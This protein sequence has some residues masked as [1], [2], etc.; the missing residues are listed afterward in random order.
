MN[1]RKKIIIIF[2]IFILLSL[3]GCYEEKETELKFDGITLKSEVVELVN[4]SLNF[5]YNKTNSITRV[6]VIYLFH[7][8]ANH[9]INKLNITIHFFDVNNNIVAV[10]GP[11][12]LRNLP[13]DYIE[14]SAMEANKISYEGLNISIIDHCKIIAIEE[15]Y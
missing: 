2:I 1:F 6:E 3:N 4:A 13:I 12:Y 10:G 15:D 9:I 7:N 5:K 14:T 11:K 8:I